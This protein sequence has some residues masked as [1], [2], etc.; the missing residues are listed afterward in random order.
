MMRNKYA[1]NKEKSCIQRKTKGI[2][3]KRTQGFKQRSHKVDNSVQDEEEHE[4][5]NNAQ[6]TNNAR[7]WILQKNDVTK[8]ETV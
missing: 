4:L 6:C 3:G 7:S 5:N 2:D 1:M 8:F